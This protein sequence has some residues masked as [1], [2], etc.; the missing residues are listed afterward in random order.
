MHNGYRPTS[1]KHN[2]ALRTGECCAYSTHAVIDSLTQSCSHRY[3]NPSNTHTYPINLILPDTTKSL[4]NLSDKR[5]ALKHR[6][7]Q[8]PFIL[9]H[10]PSFNPGIF[11]PTQ[12]HRLFH[13][14][15]AHRASALGNSAWRK[16][17]RKSLF[18]CLRISN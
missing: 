9:S 6:R 12:H 18:C 14:H 5:V 1:S 3:L 4:K 7:P 17:L 2:V 15:K 10:H 11:A 8:V 16:K 13:C